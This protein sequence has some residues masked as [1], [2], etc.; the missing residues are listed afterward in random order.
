MILLLASLPTYFNHL[1]TMLMY[2]KETLELEE[3]TNALLS[4]S[5][6]KQDR[7]DSQGD[8]L[9]VHS[10]SN[11]GGNKSKGS[12][13]NKERFQ[14]RSSAKNDVE[15]FYCHKK[16]HYKNQCKELKQHLEERKNEKKAAKSA[17]VV[18]EK[19]DDNEVD[20]DLLLV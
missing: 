6:M 16:G 19:P 1:V 17:S 18:E 8:G 10:E 12:N 13:S 15:C 4:H 7:D 2:K 11:H 20:G 5:K 14:S 3:V 9:V